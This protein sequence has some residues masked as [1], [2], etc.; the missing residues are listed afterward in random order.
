VKVSRLRTLGPRL[1]PID[2]RT[3]R[4]PPKVVESFYSSAEWK[5]VRAKVLERDEYRCVKCGCREGKLTVDHIVERKD[6]GAD[7]DMENLQTLDAK[8]HGL[9]T[10]GERVKRAA[11]EY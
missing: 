11:R 5:A 2:T 10:T 8:C 7:Y 1:K 3:V 9:K 6:G 4:P